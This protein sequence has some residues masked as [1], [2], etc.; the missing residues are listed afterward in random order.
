MTKIKSVGDLPEWFRPA[1]YE[2]N[3]TDRDW[4]REIRKRTWAYEQIKSARA[5]PRAP[6]HRVN[7]LF[8]ACYKN[9]KPS[10]REYRQ[11]GPDVPVRDMTQ[12]EAIFLAAANWT[13]TAK[14]F[15]NDCRGLMDAYAK[16]VAHGEDWASAEYDERAAEFVFNW[17][18]F[19]DNELNDMAFGSS[20]DECNP[21][22]SHSRYYEGYPLVVDTSFDDETILNDMKVWLAMVRRDRESKARRP[23]NQNDFDDWSLYKIREIHDL[24]LWSFINDIKIP[25]RVIAAALW[26]HASD[27]FSPLDV[28]RTTARKKYREIISPSAELRL[29]GQ[30]VLAYGENFL[31]D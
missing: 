28:L 22:L 3:I 12:R 24:D 21:L 23:F 1:L 17:H 19:R 13:D 18:E 2:R 27:D 14:H 26:P 10:W 5:D 15:F 31:D 11:D 25:D 7:T 8:R 29:Y 6:R 16:E 20:L 9:L 30:L 4:Y